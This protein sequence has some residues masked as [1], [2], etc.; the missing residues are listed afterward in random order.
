MN[1]PRQDGKRSDRS[2]DEPAETALSNNESGNFELIDL[3]RAHQK[4]TDTGM[5]VADGFGGRRRDD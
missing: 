2:P 3:L 5:P 1:E 4:A